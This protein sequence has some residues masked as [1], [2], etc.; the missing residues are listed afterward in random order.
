M[1]VKNIIIVNRS[2]FKD[3]KY[4]CFFLFKLIIIKSLPCIKLPNVIKM[5]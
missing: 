4:L 3:V 1:Y 5:K 2:R